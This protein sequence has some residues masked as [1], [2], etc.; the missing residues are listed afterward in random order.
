[1]TVEEKAL[2]TAL[3]GDISEEER[4]RQGP[5]SGRQAVPQISK[6]HGGREPVRAEIPVP[7]LLRRTAGMLEQASLH[8]RSSH[9]P[10]VYGEGRSLRGL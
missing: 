4:E 8:M 3:H 1:M 5:S 7:S 6:S 2:S 9:L 10:G